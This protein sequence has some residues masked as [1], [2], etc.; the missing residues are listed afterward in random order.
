MDTEI[1]SKIDEIGNVFHKFK[2]ANDERL[3]KIEKGNNSQELENKT[4]K[5]AD[6]IASISE[7]VQK[8][9]ALQNTEVKEVEVESQEYKEAVSNYLLKGNDK[10]ILELKQ[11]GTRIDTDGGFLVNPMIDAEIGKRFFETSPMRQIATVKTLQNANE[12]KKRVRKTVVTSGGWTGEGSSMDKTGTGAY[13]SISIYAHKHYAQP[14]FTTEMLEDTGLNVESEILSEANDLLVREENTAFI[15]GT[16]AN[17]PKG[18]T[19]YAA[20]ASAGT[21]EF[22]KIEQIN[23]G[24]AGAV[25]ADGLI[26]LQNSLFEVYQGSAKF[27]MARAT[28]AALIKLKGTDVYFFNNPLDKSVGTPFNLLGKPVVFASDMP[29]VAANSLSIAY[30]DFAKGYTIVDKAGTK[31]IRDPY[32]S[33]GSVIFHV[34]KR[35]GGGITDFDAIKIQKLAA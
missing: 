21:Y 26:D 16:G 22:N 20:W 11:L 35:T 6:D 34:E 17:E 18:L 14:D 8:L 33:K 29:A 23:S 28:F 3:E 25:T 15:S 13:G 32:T 12:Y 24:S 1:I 4:S 31:I 10:L 5:M 9:Q 7:S 27:L 2:K 30:G 19:Y